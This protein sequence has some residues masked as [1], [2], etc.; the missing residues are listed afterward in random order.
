MDFGDFTITKR[1]VIFSVVI[2]AVML[3][4]G[5]I[6]HGTIDNALMEKHQEYNMALRIDDNTDMFTYGMSTNVGNAYVY[7]VLDTVDPVSFEE[8]EGEYSYIKKV[9]EKYTKH[10]R[11]VTETYTDADGKTKTRTKTETYWTWDTV[12]TWTDHSTKITFLGVEFDYGTIDMPGSGYITTIKESSKI[13]YQYYGAPTT[14]TGTLYADLRDNTINNV[15][16][17]HYATIEEAHKY[18]TSKGELI[19]FWIFWIPLTG[20]AMFAFVFVDNHWLEDRRKSRY[21][22]KMDYNRGLSRTVHA[23]QKPRKNSQ[24][25]RDNSW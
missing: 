23:V 15:R 19:A 10:T 14:C 25:R 13:R 11:T 20:G 17:Y 21:D 1:E 9:K 2:L 6:I 16:M 12:Q 18:M 7:G 5:F 3:T 4:F 22:R 8:I 24:Y